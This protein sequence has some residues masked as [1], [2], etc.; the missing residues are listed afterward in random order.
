MGRLDAQLKERAVRMLSESRGSILADDCCNFDFVE[1][2]MTGWVGFKS[3]TDTE[4][5]SWV[6][7]YATMNDTDEWYALLREVEAQLAIEDMLGCSIDD[8]PF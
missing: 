8:C 3:C 7:S 2:A 1:L 4:L 6:N 5:L